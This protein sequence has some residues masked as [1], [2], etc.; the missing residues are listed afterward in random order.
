MAPFIMNQ[1]SFH[2]LIKQISAKPQAQKNKGMIFFCEKH[3]LRH[4]KVNIYKHLADKMW[5]YGSNGEV[6][7][8]TFFVVQHVDV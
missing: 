7:F 5:K 3:D 2:E 1:L 4:L 8:Q 6:S